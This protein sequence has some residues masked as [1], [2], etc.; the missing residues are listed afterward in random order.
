MVLLFAVM[1]VE[2]LGPLVKDMSEDVL[3]SQCRVVFSSVWKASL[4][5]FQTQV[6]GDSWG[7][8]ALPFLYL[9]PASAI[10]FVS[11]VI[12]IQGGV[13]N[14]V[15]SVVVSSACKANEDDMDCQARQ[16]EKDR[17]KAAGLLGN[18]FV[19]M[20]D[21][22]DGC[23]TADELLHAYDTNHEFRNLSRTLQLGRD[24]LEQL[25]I[26]MDTDQNGL[27]SLDEF[28]ACVSHTQA[29]D[30]R[31]VMMFM[32]L[33][34]FQLD[35]E[36]QQHI[37]ALHDALSPNVFAAN[38]AW[39]RHMGTFLSRKAGGVERA[40]RRKRQVRGSGYEAAISKLNNLF[41]SFIGDGDA[42]LSLDAFKR[43]FQEHS[44]ST[45]MDCLNLT[46]LDV[47]KLFHLMDTDCDARVDAGEFVEGIAL[48]TVGGVSAFNLGVRND[49]QQV[50]NT[51]RTYPGGL[52]AP[53][54]L[55]PLDGDVPQLK[56]P[57][58]LHSMG[59]FSVD[60]GSS[61]TSDSKGMGG[62]QPLGDDSCPAW[63]SISWRTSVQSWMPCTSPHNR[64]RTLRR[65]TSLWIVSST[66]WLHLQS[67]S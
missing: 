48:I 6:A 59:S 7:N 16:L 58:K 32:K 56:Q 26:Y 42:R 24:E 44:V 9:Y 35:A 17:K 21:N 15:L 38:N 25:F 49:V 20:D 47:D 63:P 8:C 62:P 29:A 3:E 57:L 12:L 1:S 55:H 64:P 18:L 23:L 36:M 13:M 61:E 33:Q 66:S 5:F 2:L 43:F 39:E 54:P 4:L 19:T 45:G 28:I 65:T 37:A 22:G 40:A 50:H 52:P 67:L 53:T 60:C 30:L 11:A 14:L 10:L 51:L 34:L 41:Q 27:V 31:V 46:Q